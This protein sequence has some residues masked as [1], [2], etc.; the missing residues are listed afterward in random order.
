MFVISPA[1]N[2][3]PLKESKAYSSVFTILSHH[4]DDAEIQ[5]TGLLALAGLLEVDSYA[6]G[7]VARQGDHASIMA[8]VMSHSGSSAVVAHGFECLRVIAGYA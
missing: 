2:D 6:A 1:V 3:V 4:P 5:G 8:T 7:T